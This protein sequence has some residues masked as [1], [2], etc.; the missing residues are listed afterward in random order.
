MKSLAE[1]AKKKSARTELAAA[2]TRMTTMI[3]NYE[4]S[5]LDESIVA[6]AG[7]T[8]VLYVVLPKLANREHNHLIIHRVLESCPRTWKQPS[9]GQTNFLATSG[10]G[11]V[12]D[13]ELYIMDYN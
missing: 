11:S 12:D 7:L 4:T 1:S 6:T 9:C 3:C 10:A 5:I 2:V 8:K 13:T